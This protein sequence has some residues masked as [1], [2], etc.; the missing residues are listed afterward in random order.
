MNLSCYHFYVTLYLF[1]AK[2]YIFVPGLDCSRIFQKFAV[3]SAES[4][5]IVYVYRYNVK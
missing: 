4:A 2:V 3:D 5:D 1:F